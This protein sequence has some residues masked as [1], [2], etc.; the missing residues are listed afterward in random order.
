MGEPVNAMLGGLNL[1]QLVMQI[2]RGESPPPAPL[3]RLGV[4][5][6][7][8]FMILLSM[9]YEGQGRGALMRELRECAAGRG[10]YENSEDELTRPHEDS[11]SRLPRLWVTAQLLAWPGIARRIVDK[12]VENYSLP[13]SAT[14]TI[15]RLP[16]N[17][18]DG[19]F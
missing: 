7:N 10:L 8:L 4:C 14:E 3:A 6:H 18:L 13:E 11:L 16:L 12:T 2:S 19:E 1:P 5:T 17:L 9:A 15:K